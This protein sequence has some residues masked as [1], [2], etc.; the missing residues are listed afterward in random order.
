V[1]A[2]PGPASARHAGNEENSELAV[3]DCWSNPWGTPSSGGPLG[4]SL[5]TH[6]EHQLSTQPTAGVLTCGDWAGSGECDSPSG[7]AIDRLKPPPGRKRPG[8]P[9]MGGKSPEIVVQQRI[10][11]ALQFMRKSAIGR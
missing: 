4:L 3:L 5:Q 7:G 8:A 2:R 1:G 10:L 6:M 9:R 11:G